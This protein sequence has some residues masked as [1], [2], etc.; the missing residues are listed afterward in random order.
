MICVTLELVHIS[1]EIIVTTV[2]LQRTNF[3]SVGL[4]K[5]AVQQC[6]AVK[7]LFV[8]TMS[9]HHNR[10]HATMSNQSYLTGWSPLQ[11]Y[12]VKAQIHLNG[13]VDVVICVETCQ[14]PFQE[15]ILA[16]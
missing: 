5:T 14:P 7:Q 1:T 12:P 2:L 8:C 3:L 4:P 9:S 13:S 16:S 15:G 6:D 11:P 10:I